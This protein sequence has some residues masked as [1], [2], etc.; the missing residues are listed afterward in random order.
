MEG[1]D[2]LL[3]G[4]GFL[5]QFGGEATET[6]GNSRSGPL[7]GLS[8]L[9]LFGTV[10]WLVVELNLLAD[11]GYSAGFMVLLGLGALVVAIGIPLLLFWLRIV[12][13]YR[14]AG[15]FL[16]IAALAVLLTAGSS[17]ALRHQTAGPLP[18][19]RPR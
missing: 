7:A 5:F 19:A 8:F 11:A 17:C 12:H 4:I 3:E 10:P 6:I 18:T 16:V 1:L 9:S 13:S 14:P 2:T 15:F